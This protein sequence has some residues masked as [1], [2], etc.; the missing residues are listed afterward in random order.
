MEQSCS[1][2]SVKKRCCWRGLGANFSRSALTALIITAHSLR[3]WWSAAQFDVRGT[4]LV[5]TCGQ[6][7]LFGRPPLI[8]CH[9][10]RLNSGTAAYSSGAKR[11]SRRR[12]RPASQPATRP[13]ELSLLAEAPPALRPRR[14]YGEKISQAVS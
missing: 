7:R 12:R 1:V 5:L 8:H 4:M 14:C 9:V 6:V 13:S 10:G 3:D 2:M 11:I